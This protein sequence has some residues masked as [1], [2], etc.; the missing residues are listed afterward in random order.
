MDDKDKF[1]ITDIFIPYDELT[2]TLKLRAEIRQ[3]RREAE[4]REA[5]AREA[6][7]REAEDPQPSEDTSGI[8]IY[9]LAKT[10]VSSTQRVLKWFRKA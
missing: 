6:A 7:A 5:E 9:P 2:N 1:D 8:K 4:A 10:H 3:L